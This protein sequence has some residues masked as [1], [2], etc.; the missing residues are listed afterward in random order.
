MAARKRKKNGQAAPSY[1]ESHWGRDVTDVQYA[2]I[3]EPRDNKKLIG[4]GAVHSIVYITRKG[5]DGEDV[6]YEH[7]FSS[8]EP[9]LLAYGDKDGRLYIIGGS[10]RVTRHGIVG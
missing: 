3:N 4:L 7:K 5:S 6:E 9:P 2:R 1:K 8:R 10:Y